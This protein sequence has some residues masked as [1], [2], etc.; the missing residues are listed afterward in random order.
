M[1]R[2]FSAAIRVASDWAASALAV[3]CCWACSALAA[4]RTCSALARRALPAKTWARASVAAN[5]L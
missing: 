1:S 5:R 2:S 3:A 4:I